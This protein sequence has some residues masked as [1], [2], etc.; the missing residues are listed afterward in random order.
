MSTVLLILCNCSFDW[1]KNIG[2]DRQSFG[3]LVHSMSKSFDLFTR[4]TDFKKEDLEYAALEK[5]GEN[6]IFELLFDF[7]ESKITIFHGGKKADTICN[8]ALRNIF[9]AISMYRELE[10]IQIVEY[11]FL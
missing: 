1:D 8:I 2:A 11:E 6:Q 3:I 7:L 10:E 4:I 9:P 5:F